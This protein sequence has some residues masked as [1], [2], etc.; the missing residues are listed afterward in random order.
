MWNILPKI[1]SSMLMPEADLA[2]L[3]KLFWE[4]DRDKMLHP[5]N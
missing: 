3:A 4:W 2:Q 5:A 1:I